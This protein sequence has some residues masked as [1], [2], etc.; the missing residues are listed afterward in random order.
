M[1][2]V[3]RDGR[4]VWVWVSDD[5]LTVMYDALVEHRRANELRHGAAVGRGD[6]VSTTDERVAL[7]GA[8]LDRLSAVPA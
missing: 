5:E 4:G 2:D 6:T 3:Q 7:A 1:T 8:V